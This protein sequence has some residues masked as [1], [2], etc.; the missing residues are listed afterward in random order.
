LPI[1]IGL[2]RFRA[3]RCF[4]GEVPNPSVGAGLVYHDVVF[5][6]FNHENQAFDTVIGAAYVLTHEC[7]VDSDNARHF[8]DQV[9]VCPLLPLEDLVATFEP[10]MG[11]DSFRQWLASAAAN[12]I[13]RIFFLPPAPYGGALTNGAVLYL[14]QLCSTHID[15]F[16]EAVALCSL[17]SHALDR[18]DW[19]LQNLLFRP[20]AD[21]Q[22]RLR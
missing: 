13:V 15:V 2:V 12:E 11:E 4:Y 1:C 16:N 10:E 19:K 20:K 6:V 22:P 14:N 17:S 9:V 18:L 7:D 3:S 21:P 5:S 8:N